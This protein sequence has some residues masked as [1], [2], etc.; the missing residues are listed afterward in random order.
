MLKT[1]PESLVEIAVR[2]TISEWTYSSVPP[3]AVVINNAK[4][5]VAETNEAVRVKTWD[6]AWAE[7]NRAM[8]NAPWGKTPTWSTPQIESAVNS[9]GW[10]NI[11]A[12]EEKNFNT[13]RAQIRQIYESVCKRVDESARNQYLLGKNPQGILGIPLPVTDVVKQ[14]GE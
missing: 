9:I 14:I 2:K 10:S 4:S 6:E 11:Q 1:L 12:V 7:I 3:V 8:F 13:M 5:I